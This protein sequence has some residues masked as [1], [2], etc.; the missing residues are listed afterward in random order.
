MGSKIKQLMQQWPTGQVATTRWLSSLGVDRRLADKYVQSGWLERIGHGAYRR[1]GTHINWIGAVQTLQKQLSLTVHPGGI[2]A[3]E[4]HGYSH[5]VA[6]GPREVLLF[7]NPGTKLPAWF[8]AYPWSR[9]V[10]LVTSRLFASNEFSGSRLSID[11]VELDVAT[12]ERAALEM[13]YLVPKRQSFEE[14]CQVELL[15]RC[16]P[17]VV[18]APEFALKG[19]TAINMFLHDMP[20]LS[21]DIDLT[22]LPLTDRD[23]AIIHIRNKLMEIADRLRATV[24]GAKTQLLDSAAPKLLVDKSGARIKLEPSIVVR[25]SLVPPIKRELCAK[26]LWPTSPVTGARLRSCCDRTKSRSGICMRATSSA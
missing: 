20:R 8:E 21:V 1:A 16:L 9:P 2:T 11:L 18:S 3:L 12:P 22:Y 7:G 10:R 26:L 15:L 5:Y 19:G 4:L 23:T 13:M 14:A 24:P 25:G 6:F 17:A